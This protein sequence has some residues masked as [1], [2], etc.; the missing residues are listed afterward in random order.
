MITKLR[1]L[2]EILATL[3]GFAAVLGYGYFSFWWLMEFAR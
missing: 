3:A 1:T 2:L